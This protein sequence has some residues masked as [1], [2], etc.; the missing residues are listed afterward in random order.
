MPAEPGE[1]GKSHESGEGIPRKSRSSHP[2]LVV[3]PDLCQSKEKLDAAMP[4]AHRV[5]GVLSTAH[6]RHKVC[7]DT[8]NFDPW[9]P[10]GG[11]QR[12]DWA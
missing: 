10:G 4:H 9:Q 1:L 7:F 2:V 5:E 11:G 12:H 3:T 8:K 6:M